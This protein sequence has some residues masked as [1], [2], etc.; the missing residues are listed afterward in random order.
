MQN[1]N[2][3]IHSLKNELNAH[4]AIRAWIIT[5]ENVHRRERYFL[6]E[7]DRLAVDQDRNIFTRNISVR[8][9]T[10]AVDPKKQGEIQKKLF[11]SLPLK[12]QI[13]SAIEAAEQTDLPIWNLPET[14]P[15]SI[16]EVKTS[17]PKMA[18]DLDSVMEEM[19]RE[20]GR[21]ISQKALFNSAEL[22]L[23]S[24]DR[25]LYLSNGLSHRSTQS[26]IYTEAAFSSSRTTSEGKQISDEYLTSRWGVALNGISVKEIFA[27]TADRAANSLDT[28]KPKTGKYSVI[29]DADVLSTLMSNS[30]SLLSA[31]NSFHGLPFTKPGDLWIEDCVGDPLTLILDPSLDF[32]AGTAAVSDQGL[33]QKPLT[34]IENNQVKATLVDKQYSD[35][36]G[37]PSTTSRGNVVVLPGKKTHAELS[38]AAPQVIEILQFSG[39]FCD[40]HSGTF[41]SEIRLAKLYDNET[42]KVTYLK[43]GSL[44]GSIQDNFKGLQLCK[45][46]VQHAHFSSE[47]PFGQGYFGPEYAL[48]SEVSVVG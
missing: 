13:D 41:S 35:Y 39:L 32:G 31:Q 5:E 26:R 22:F 48:L 24:H 45:S 34:L 2:W 16:P 27:E 18:E 44:S 20:V 6:N 30:L 9:L 11:P 12:A 29:I 42:G 1:L 46:T 25:H 14:V 3:S 23:S 4:K 43:G 8:I 38:K 33:L 15:S 47:S 19:T 40:P 37:Q 17:D 28:H 21:A 10:R 7:K 36:L